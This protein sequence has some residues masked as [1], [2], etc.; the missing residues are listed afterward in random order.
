MSRA[1]S[2]ATSS[3]VSLPLR[4]IVDGCEV[5]AGTV[6]LRTY[7]YEPETSAVAR[8][9]AAARTTLLD[10]AQQIAA[11]YGLDHFGEIMN[12]RDAALTHADIDVR[13]G[14][15]TAAGRPDVG[16][17]HDYIRYLCRELAHALVDQLPEGPDKR[18]A[19]ENL[20]AVMMRGNRAIALGF[21]DRPAAPPAVPAP[22]A[23][24]PVPRP[25]TAYRATRA[26]ARS[27]LAVP[28]PRAGDDQG[29]NR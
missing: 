16:E 3:A 27:D 22:A 19:I 11:I 14:F 26:P 18:L 17:R 28:R 4:V 8:Y 24:R 21:R 9:A 5:A 20:E 6:E 1:L 29:P 10:L 2:P 25:P 12:S 23:S 15:H 13:F 7:A